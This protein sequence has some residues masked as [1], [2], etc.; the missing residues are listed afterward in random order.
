MLKIL[1]TLLNVYQELIILLKGK[2]RRMRD[3]LN[4]L[5]DIIALIIT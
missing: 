4:V 2:G 5:L 3:V 1:E